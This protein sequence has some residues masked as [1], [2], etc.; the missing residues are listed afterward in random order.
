MP[1][2]TPRLPVDDARTDTDRATETTGAA[3][4]TARRLAKL[5]TEVLAPGIL[6][7]VILLVVGWHSTRT[8]SGLGWGL[9]ASLFCGIIPYGF[10]IAG[11]RLGRW[12]DRHIKIRQ[13]RFVPLTV[14][15]GSVVA[16]MLALVVLGAPREIFA[17]VVAMLAGLAVTLTVTKW[18]KV[19]VH[20]AV[21][22]GVS[23]ILILT[24]GIAMVWAF[25]VVALTGWSRVKLR[26][27]TPAQ[28]VVGTILG[29]VTAATVFTLVR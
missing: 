22:G 29:T 11:V 17:L 2:H 23:A 6:V 27:H 25:P 5:I 18:W 12:T 1:T 28:T 14:T 24:Y 16:G 26:D 8:L 13:Q 15:M 10:I 9:L 3:P 19:S 20:T 4:D 7:V 21:A